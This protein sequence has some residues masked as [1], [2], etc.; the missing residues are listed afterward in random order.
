MRIAGLTASASRIVFLP[1]TDLRRLI[2]GWTGYT[3]IPDKSSG[4]LAFLKALRQ[5]A[6]PQS[7]LLISFFA[8]RRGSRDEALV[9]RMANCSGSSLTDEGN[10][11]ELGDRLSYAGTRIH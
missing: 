2:V 3:H 10:D 7:P 6:L 5:R 8:R 9:Y 4:E 11:W 1:A